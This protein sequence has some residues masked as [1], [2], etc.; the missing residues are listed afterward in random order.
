MV[1]APH[2]NR[3]SMLFNDR[4]WVVMTFLFLGI[5]I[6][7]VDRGNLSVAAN[8]IMKDFQ[9]SPPRMGVLLSSFFWTY[10]LFMIPAGFLVDRFGIKSTYLIGLGLWSIASAL[11]GVADSFSATGRPPCNVGFRRIHRT[12][13]QHRLHQTQFR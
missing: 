8:A 9:F 12:R 13:R 1:P 2:Y 6:S 11:I 10:A 3:K 4:R 7:Y 5:L